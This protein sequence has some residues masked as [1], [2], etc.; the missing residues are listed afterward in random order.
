MNFTMNFYRT[1]DTTGGCSNVCIGACSP[2]I[3]VVEGNALS[4]INTVAPN[5]NNFT[6]YPN[7]FYNNTTIAYTLNSDASVKLD[8]YNI[9][10]AKVQSLV[11]SEQESGEYQYNFNSQNNNLSRIEAGLYF[12]SLSVDGKTNTKRIILM[13]Q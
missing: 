10:G 2:W 8:V 9:V 4:G 13:E 1:Y 5:E 6:V 3:M 11:N 12:I 7:P